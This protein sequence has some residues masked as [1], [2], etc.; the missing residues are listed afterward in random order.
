MEEPDPGPSLSRRPSL[1]DPEVIQRQTKVDSLI[2]YLSQSLGI[3]RAKLQASIDEHSIID[4]GY[5][6]PF[7]GHIVHEHHQARWRISNAIIDDFFKDKIG[8]WVECE[9]NAILIVKEYAANETRPRMSHGFFSTTLVR[10][11]A[12][13]SIMVHLMFEPEDFDGEGQQDYLLRAFTVQLGASYL[14][15]AYTKKLQE[16]IINVE[17]SD[18]NY[19]NFLELFMEDLGDGL[20]DDYHILVVLDGARPDQAS[21]LLQVI[22]DLTTDRPT[23]IFQVL[24]TGQGADEIAEGISHPT[25]QLPFPEEY[26]VLMMPIEEPEFTEDDLL[27]DPEARRQWRSKGGYNCQVWRET[28]QELGEPLPH[29]ATSTSSNNA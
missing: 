9:S 11:W 22:D 6:I 20:P 1:P 13:P 17:S 25:F 21:K 29:H 26:H 12:K 16:D 8:G 18:A 5:S 10:R 14:E 23:P 15:A 24:I 3:D 4:I 2:K 7:S 28:P 19:M 27:N